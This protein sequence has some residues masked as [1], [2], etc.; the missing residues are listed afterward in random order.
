MLST[1][2]INFNNEDKI[3]TRYIN[4]SII[5]RK[6]K[7]LQLKKTFSKK[8]IFLLE[9]RNFAIT[10]MNLAS[11]FYQIFIVI[12]LQIKIPFLVAYIIHTQIPSTSSITCFHNEA[13]LCFKQLFEKNTNICTDQQLHFQCKHYNFLD[14]CF[15]KK[16]VQ[17]QPSVVGRAASTAYKK[18][19]LQCQ[20]QQLRSSNRRRH[21]YKSTIYRQNPPTDLQFISY[22]GYLQSICISNN[23]NCTSEIF[24]QDISRCEEDIKNKAH[25]SVQEANRHSLLRMKLQA[26]SNLLQYSETKRDEECLLVRSALTDI[27]QLHQSYC[28]QTSITRCMCERLNFEYFCNISCSRLEVKSIPFNQILTW[29][30]FEGRLRSAVGFSQRTIKISTQNCFIIFIVFFIIKNF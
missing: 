4:S 9:I 14:E 23:T 12:F 18:R 5:N 22:I 20:Q 27:F 10:L 15:T 6:D 11:L 2:K 30:D 29:S 21:Q 19:R 28:L 24:R 17:C 13:E 7:D 1:S 16:D 3:F 26:S 25:G 8:T